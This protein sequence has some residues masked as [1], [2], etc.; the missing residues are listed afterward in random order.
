MLLP[1]LQKKGL[2]KF[3]GG[4][5]EKKGTSKTLSVEKL[6]DNGVL[7]SIREIKNSYYRCLLYYMSLIELGQNSKELFYIIPFN[8]PHRFS[9][10]KLK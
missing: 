2:D 5:K 3:S 4:D 6:R 9:I 7:K 1:C 10:F 8:P